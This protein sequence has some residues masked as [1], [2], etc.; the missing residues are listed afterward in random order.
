MVE[1]QD[2]LNLKVGNKEVVTLKPGVVKVVDVK[3]EELGSKKAK[4]VICLC[5]HPNAEEPIQISGIKYEKKEKLVTT[6]LWVNKDDEGNIQK[7]CALAVFLNLCGVETPA[8]LKEK[9]L[10]TV[11][12][13]S[14]YL[15]FKAY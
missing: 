14:G 4:K 13:D 11:S 2:E 10:T 5:K 15:I 9:E 12:D 7:G 3:V 6:G 1:I 8:E